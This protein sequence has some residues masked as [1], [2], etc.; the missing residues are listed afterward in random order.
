MTNS[1][2]IEKAVNNVLD[3]IRPYLKKDRGDVEF[4]RFE[5]DTSVLELRLLGNCKICPL[6]MMT[7]R[8]GIERFIIAEI[9][10]IKRVEK[11]E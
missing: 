8:A 11:V 9:P 5:E 1:K 10:E 3:T 4:V 2:D 7:L 6:Q